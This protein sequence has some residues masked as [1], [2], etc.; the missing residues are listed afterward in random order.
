MSR[1]YDHGV[2]FGRSQLLHWP[3]QADH[4]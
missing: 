4:A 1:P 2:P 3:R